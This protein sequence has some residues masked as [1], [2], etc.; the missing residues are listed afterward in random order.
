MVT[1]MH[2]TGNLPC[3]TLSVLFGYKVHFKRIIDLILKK[4]VD[5]LQNKLY[6]AVIDLD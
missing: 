3:Y 5:I 6:D 2:S 4:I 1:H